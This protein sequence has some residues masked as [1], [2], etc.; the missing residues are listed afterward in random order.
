M[1]THNGPRPRADTFRSWRLTTLAGWFIV[2]WLLTATHLLVVMKHEVFQHNGAFVLM[3]AAPPLLVGQ[4]L[5]SL[6]ILPTL[7]GLG[8]LAIIAVPS[9]LAARDPDSKLWYRVA[10]TCIAIVWLFLD[11]GLAFAA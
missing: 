6:E 2:L 11:F 7:L 10:V 4:W 5:V 1:L 3:C 8:V 9:W